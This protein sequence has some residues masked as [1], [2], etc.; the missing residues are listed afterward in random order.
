MLARD[1]R[2]E[3]ILDE[4]D[5]RSLKL[6]S[7]TRDPPQLQ[8]SIGKL[9]RLSSMSDRNYYMDFIYEQTSARKLISLHISSR[10]NRPDAR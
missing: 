9:S 1:R 2:H 6:G 3:L 10:Q 8:Y 5:R 4:Y 7:L